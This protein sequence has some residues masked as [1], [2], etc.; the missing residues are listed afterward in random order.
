[1]QIG[2]HQIQAQDPLCS[3]RSIY[4][5]YLS[6]EEDHKGVHIKQVGTEGLIERGKIG[7]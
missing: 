2:V 6:T 5:D 4:E 3:Y 7:R 1:M